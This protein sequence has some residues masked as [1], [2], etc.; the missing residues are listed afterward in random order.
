[1]AQSSKCCF[2]SFRDDIMVFFGF[3]FVCCVQLLTHVWLFATPWTVA[4]Q[5]PKSSPIKNTRVSCHF[6]LQGSSW[7]RDWTQVSCIGRHWQADSLPLS[8]Q[9]IVSVCL[10]FIICNISIYRKQLY[11]SHSL[12]SPSPPAFNLSQRQGLF[13]WWASQMSVNIHNDCNPQ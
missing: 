4:Y 13:Q 10:H 12:S 2:G 3:F 9:G 7:P 1:M 11:T 8:H 6:L 5:A